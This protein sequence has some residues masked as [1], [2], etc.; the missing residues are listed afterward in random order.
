[1]TSKHSLSINRALL[2]VALVTLT[3]GPLRAETVDFNDLPLATGSFFNG[4]TAN[5]V[6][7]DSVEQLFGDSALVGT[8]ASGG[9]APVQFTNESDT[10]FA[11]SWTGFAYSNVNNTADGSFTN[12]YAAYTGVGAGPGVG[13]NADNYAIGFG[14]LDP[15]SAQSNLLQT[16]SFDVKN[17]DPAQLALLPHFQIPSG[18]QISSLDV[19]NTTY[20]AMTMINGG[21]GATPFGAN[22]WFQLSIYGT[23]AQGQVL[24]GIYNFFLDQGANP[25]ST[26]TTLPLASTLSGATTL[27][28]NLTSS[29]VP[30]GQDDL[31]GMNTPGYFALDNV[32]ILPTPE[33]STFVLA[34][35]A[36]CGLMAVARRRRSRGA[37]AK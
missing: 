2:L 32:V 11:G 29:D 26:W 4:P 18:Y 27:Y 20:A 17:P 28:F 9:P 33:P 3:V 8:F 34:C 7:V 5:A 16:F 31:F 13:G 25:L 21:N 19:A 36:A 15:N 14:Y 6:P 10:E 24:P 35:A 37:V 1:M 22:S 30:S 23:N 12:Q